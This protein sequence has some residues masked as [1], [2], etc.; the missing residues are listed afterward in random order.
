[1]KP[2]G[3]SAPYVETIVDSLDTDRALPLLLSAYS[4]LKPAD[5]RDIAKWLVI[6]IVRYSVISDLNPGIMEDLFFS[7][8]KD[9]HTQ[10]KKRHPLASSQIAAR[11]KKALKDKSPADQQ[12]E[13][14]ISTVTL[15]DAEAKYIIRK[16]AGSIESTTGELGPDNAILE[17]IFPK[18]P[19]IADWP[20]LEELKPYLWHIGNLTMIR[21]SLGG[22][23]G[24]DPYNKKRPVYQK[25]S[26]LKMT[27]A[28][29]TEYTQWNPDS[30]KKRAA[31]L[32]DHVNRVWNFDNTSLV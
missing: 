6:F 29:A 30:V 10:S 24:N 5:V 4:N 26:E 16:L 28:V 1:M 25:H 15:K 8:A 7:L 32:A 19:K 18:K 21:G 27:R 9:V 3:E 22:N 23:I 12:I 17:H 14:S 11:V 20:N 2:L 31:A 13:T